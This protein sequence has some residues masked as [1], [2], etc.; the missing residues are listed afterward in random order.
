M[1][2][3][4]ERAQ[5]FAQ[6]SKRE[7]R[8]DAYTY[9]ILII[10]VL[11]INL[12]FLQMIVTSFKTKNEAMT[13]TAF[14]PQTLSLD[15]FKTVLFNT[16]FLS[17][18]LNSFKIASI[19]T[20]LCIVF[21]VMAGYAI[22]R[23]RGKVFSFYT[24][25]MLLLQLFPG[26]LM[27]IPLFVIFR[28]MGLVDTHLS[29]ILS[30]T[31]GNL[32]FS[33]WLIKGF[34]DAIP[35]DMEQAGMIDGCSQ[36]QAFLRLVLPVSIPGISTVAIFTFINSWGEFMVASVLLRSA[37]LHT[38]TLGLQQFVMQYGTD[39]TSL[40]AASTI[41][42]IPTLIFLL[43]AQKYLIQGVSAGSVKG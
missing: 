1:S 43:V 14:F 32:A 29:L 12:P 28:N 23:F 42:S 19:V 26:V 33:I 38:I 3:K 24:T 27:L 22:S 5:L 6:K 17:N 20:F 18:M 11:L 30:Y 37:N 31:T 2:I 9:V 34:F 40:M 10:M 36:F 15:S 21:S 16:N 25:M 35:T 4:A 8:A 41:C 39:W 7:K 13:S